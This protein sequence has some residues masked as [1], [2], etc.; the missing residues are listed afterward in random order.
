MAWREALRDFYS[1]IAA[2]LQASDHAPAGAAW[3]AVHVAGRPC[4]LPMAQ[5]GEIFPALEV[6]RLPYTRTW[7]RGVANLRGELHSVIDL[8]GFLPRSPDPQAATA[9]PLAALGGWFVTLHPALQMRCAL[10][11]DRLEGMRPAG[12]FGPELAAPSPA[13]A[14]TCPPWAC[15]WRVDAEGGSWLALDLHRLAQEPAF[16]DAGI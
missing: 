14:A 11:I 5:T 16:L 7:L 10:H 3:L 2:R 12:D 1:R 8:T 13:E 4:L 15:A 6:R 9:A